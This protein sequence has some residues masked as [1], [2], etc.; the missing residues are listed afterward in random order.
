M[1]GKKK[2]RKGGAVPE[3]LVS[4][5]VVEALRKEY[6]DWTWESFVERKQPVKTVAG[7]IGM[8]RQGFTKVLRRKTRMGFKMFARDGG[9]TIAAEGWAVELRWV[10]QRSNNCCVE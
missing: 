1:K 8:T 6:F 7:A 2:A 4:A 3:P 10:V 5:A 9:I